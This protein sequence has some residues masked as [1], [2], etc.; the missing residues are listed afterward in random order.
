MGKMG[1][2]NTAARGEIVQVQGGHIIRGTGSKDRHSKVFTAKGPRDRRLRLSA[3][4]AIQFYD[5]QDR[6]GYDRPS[7]AVDWLIKKAKASIDKLAQLPPWDP[8]AS[9]SHTVDVNVESTGFP[10]AHHTGSSSFFPTSNTISFQ[11]Y[12]QDDQFILGNQDLCLS[13]HTLQDPR[14]HD[15][16]ILQGSR[17]SLGFDGGWPGSQHSHDLGRLLFNSHGVL[18]GQQ[19]TNTIVYPHRGTLQSN[20]F[21]HYGRV[22]ENHHDHQEISG[23]GH[24]LDGFIGFPM[25]NQIHDG[26]YSLS[27]NKASSSSLSPGSSQH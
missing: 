26:G 18:L 4:T 27:N 6:L 24:G 21:S 20:D 25:P 19:G 8:M 12:P 15:P 2:K 10:V 1:L 9:S 17:L 14:S 16:E 3:H 5:I 11:N 7:K 22:S 13:L 23:I